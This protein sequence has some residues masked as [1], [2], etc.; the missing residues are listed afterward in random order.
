[1]EYVL[2]INEKAFN[3]KMQNCLVERFSFV[4]FSYIF[5]WAYAES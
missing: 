5:Y 1:M 2:G 4:L 3:Y